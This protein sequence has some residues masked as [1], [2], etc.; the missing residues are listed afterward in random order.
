MNA[1]KPWSP[2]FCANEIPELVCP[3]CKHNDCVRVREKE[4]YYDADTVE[5]YC[6]EC[7]AELEV[8]SSVEITFHDPELVIYDDEAES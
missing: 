2:P 3:R 6:A 1:P 5:A 8:C 4:L 7:Q